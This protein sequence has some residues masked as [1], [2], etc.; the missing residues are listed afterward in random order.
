[1][2]EQDDLL[3]MMSRLNALKILFLGE[4]GKQGLLSLIEEKTER[5]ERAVDR[6]EHSSTSLVDL[7]LNE[8]Q[9][10]SRTVAEKT[11][12]AVRS[13]EYDK[14]EKL[15]MENLV[16]LSDESAEKA[17]IGF[18]DKVR[19]RNA[20][21]K[22]EELANLKKKNKELSSKVENSNN[23]QKKSRLYLKASIFLSV[24]LLVT[25][26]LLLFLLTI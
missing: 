6:L 5:L 17:V 4:G 24:A 22:E 13:S 9:S 7:Q 8:L 21:R 2:V 23:Y 3:R 10:L 26:G 19:E 15:T 18:I 20:G 14:I 16:L 25:V 1:M 12:V 11:T